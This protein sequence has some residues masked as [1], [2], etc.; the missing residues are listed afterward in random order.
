[1]H[2]CKEK[3]GW[4]FEEKK[5]SAW[6]AE[7]IPYESYRKMHWHCDAFAHRTRQFCNHL[8]YDFIWTTS[9]FAFQN[10]RK[11]CMVT[12]EG[13]NNG[14]Q[15]RCIT[16]PYF[17]FPSEHAFQHTRRVISHRKILLSGSQALNKG[18]TPVKWRSGEVRVTHMYK[19]RTQLA[20]YAT[21]LHESG[22]GPPTFKTS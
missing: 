5:S 20:Y 11:V 18:I 2:I 4:A 16:S 1:M 14:C 19:L 10:V 3:W 13:L 9:S 21:K 8:T 15:R 17:C 12:S 22:F 6:V 7:A